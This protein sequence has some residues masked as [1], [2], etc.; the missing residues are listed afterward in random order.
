MGFLLSCWRT[1]SLTQPLPTCWPRIT[2]HCLHAPVSQQ[3]SQSWKQFSSPSIDAWEP[4]C[5]KGCS[6]LVIPPP[7]LSPHN[8]KQMCYGFKGKFVVDTEKSAVWGWALGRRNGWMV[9]GSLCTSCQGLQKTFPSL[10]QHIIS[11]WPMVKSNTVHEIINRY[12]SEYLKI[13]LQ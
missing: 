8:C 5:E 7:E 1:I 10:P 3:L 9:W 2:E 6:S 13:R 4:I 12:S 11:Q